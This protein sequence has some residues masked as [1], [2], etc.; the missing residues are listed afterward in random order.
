M[1]L[2]LAAQ[3]ERGNHQSAKASLGVLDKLKHGYSFCLPAEVLPEIDELAVAPLGVVHQ[4]TINEM[5]QLIP[6]DCP[7][8][9]Q[10]FA[11]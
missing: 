11:A 10:S 5:G 6:K 7:T 2:D 9:G 1:K 4:G 8:H 3:L